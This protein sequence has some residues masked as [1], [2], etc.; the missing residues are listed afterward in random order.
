MSTQLLQLLPLRFPGYFYTV[1]SVS[2]ELEDY[3]T[4]FIFLHYPKESRFETGKNYIIW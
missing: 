4:L 2:E 3:R 1:Q